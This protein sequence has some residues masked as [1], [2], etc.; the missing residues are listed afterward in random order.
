MRGSRPA[1]LVVGSVQLGLAYGAANRTGKPAREAAL[2]A[3][4]GAPPMPASRS[5]IRRAPMAMPKSGW[6][7]RFPGRQGRAH[8]H[9]TFAARPILRRDAHRASG[10]RQGGREHRRSRCAAL[11]RERL[12]CLLLHRAQHRTAYDG[13]IWERLIEHLEE[14]IS[15][16]LGVSVQS[17]A[18]AHRRACRAASVSHIQLPFNLLDWRWREAG[19]ID[20]LRTRATSPFMRAASS[21]KALLA[22]RDPPRL[23]ARAGRRCARSSSPGSTKPRAPSA[24]KASPTSCLA[25]ARGQNWIDGVVVGMETRRPSSTRICASAMR[26]PLPPGGLRRHRSLRARACPKRFS[27]PRNGRAMRLELLPPRRHGCVPLGRRRASG[28]RDG[29]RARRSRRAGSSSTAATRSG[30]TRLRART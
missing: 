5:S 13:A 14:G 4:C 18:E 21:F 24:A 9:Q 1:E 28:T 22:A 2:A 20:A 19:V 16:P 10:A 15:L 29:V 23:A 8:D 3:S 6:A 26:P 12:D 25:Y 30:L 17:P 11:R 7:K 27:I